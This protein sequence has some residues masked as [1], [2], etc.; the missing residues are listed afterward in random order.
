MKVATKR[1]ILQVLFLVFA[2]ICG[3]MLDARN[4]KDDICVAHNVVCARRH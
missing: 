4:D 1:L 3:M 2:F